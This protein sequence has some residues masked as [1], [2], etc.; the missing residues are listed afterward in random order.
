MLG[1]VATWNVHVLSGC[2][3]V[4]VCRLQKNDKR[5]GRDVDD[6]DDDDD[7]GTA[8]F[9]ETHVRPGSRS[10]SAVASL[11][12]IDA[13]TTKRDEKFRQWILTWSRNQDGTGRPRK[14][15][16]KERI[17]CL[18]DF[19][20]MAFWMDYLWSCLPTVGSVDAPNRASCICCRQVAVS[21][22]LALKVGETLSPFSVL[23]RFIFSFRSAC[24]DL[25]RSLSALFLVRWLLSLRM[26]WFVLF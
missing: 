26:R 23:A 14:R 15:R 18:L 8:S 7:P 13:G 4:S 24:V 2:L 12:M 6:D 17:V 11:K 9:D 22:V 25:Y 1:L 5:S 20:V 10:I 16:L 21:P 19:V 3:S